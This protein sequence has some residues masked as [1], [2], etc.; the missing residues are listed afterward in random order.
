MAYKEKF[1]ISIKKLNQYLE[2]VGRPQFNYDVLKSAYDSDPRIQAI[3]KDF[4]QETITLK[5][6]E[7]DDLDV[8]NNAADSNGKTVTQMAK[9]AVDLNDL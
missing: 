8:D 4:D 1:K 6:D 2:N 3:V 7:T 9:S 5:S